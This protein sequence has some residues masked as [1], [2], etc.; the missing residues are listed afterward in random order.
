MPYCIQCGKELHDNAQFCFYCGAKKPESDPASPATES[1]EPA[2][3]LANTEIPEP[4]EP[5]KKKPVLR[6]V[7]YAVGI[8]VAVLVVGLLIFAICYMLGPKKTQAKEQAKKEVE[9]AWQEFDENMELVSIT[10]DSVNVDEWDSDEIEEYIAEYGNTGII[11][12]DGNQYD[13]YRDYWES[14]GYDPRSDTYHIFTVKG[15]YHVTDHRKQDYE[16]WYC[17]MVLH[18]VNENSWR[19]EKTELELPDELRQYA[20]D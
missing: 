2:P 5:K 6:V 7:G 4:T 13:T 12:V 20:L 3:Q 11:D 14:R 18:I 1:P 8:S 16:G 15:Q 9:A 17:V 10:Y 19:I